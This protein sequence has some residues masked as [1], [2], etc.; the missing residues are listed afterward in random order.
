LAKS[1]NSQFPE[2]Q[3]PVKIISQDPR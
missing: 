3:S 2:H 1:D